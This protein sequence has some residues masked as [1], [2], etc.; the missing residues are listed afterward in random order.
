MKTSARSSR[1]NGSPN[2]HSATTASPT[3]QAR[4]ASNAAGSRTVAAC[5]AG[6]RRHSQ[7]SLFFVHDQ[8]GQ[9]GLRIARPE[10]RVAIAKPAAAYFCRF[11]LISPRSIVFPAETTT[12]S[13]TVADPTSRPRPF[14]LIV[15]D[16]PPGARLFN[17][18]RPSERDSP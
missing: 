1:P 14:A 3:P 13:A 6:R 8:S 17:T 10:P 4:A 12:F 7:S 5:R 18:N 15:Y 16:S 9:S 11:S 2:T